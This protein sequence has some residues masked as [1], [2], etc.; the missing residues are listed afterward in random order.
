[1]CFGVVAGI[2]HTPLV[3]LIRNCNPRVLGH[4][5]LWGQVVVAGQHM[6]SQM[7][8]AF[9]DTTKTGEITSRLAADTTT[10]SDQASAAA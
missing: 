9:F 3:I 1:L 7:E 10:V 4:F 2:Y 8:V 5:F 6:C